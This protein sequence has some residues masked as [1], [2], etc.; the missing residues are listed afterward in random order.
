MLTTI[1]NP[2]DPF[3]DFN[4]WYNFDVSKG[5]NSSELLDRLT[6][7]SEVSPEFVTQSQINE[8]ID[9]IVSLN[10]NGMYKKVTKEI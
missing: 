5:Y 6:F 7:T 10:P 2:F 8:A 1:D 9:K 4:Q 3:E